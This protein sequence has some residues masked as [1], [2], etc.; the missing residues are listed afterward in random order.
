MRILLDVDGV[1]ADCASAAVACAKRL[2]PERKRDFEIETITDFDFAVSWLLTRSQ[3]AHL[4]DCML[5]PKFCARL[6]R[7]AGASA[8][9]R[10]LNE[11]G[12]VT[13]VTSPLEGS[14]YW[15]YER[16][17]W[18]ARHFGIDER[19]VVFRSDKTR[20]SGDYLIDD[21]I[22]N[23]A[24]W[25]AAHGRQRALCIARPWNVDYAGPRFENYSQLTAYLSARGRS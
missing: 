13:V 4:R 19:D 25:G 12:K 5:Q 1:L 10:R 24:P 16:V 21:A 15:M 17:E 3:A 11:L 22:H 20:E 2:W 18:L 8:F 6:E 14:K 23:L 7:Y 9:V